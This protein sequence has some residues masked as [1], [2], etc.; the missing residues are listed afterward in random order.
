[1]QGPMESKSTT[2]VQAERLLLPAEDASVQ[3]KKKGHPGERKSYREL[4]ELSG[5]GWGTRR[6]SGRTWNAAGHRGEKQH[7]GSPLV[8]SCSGQNRYLL[9]VLFFFFSCMILGRISGQT[10]G[11]AISHRSGRRVD[12]EQ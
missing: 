7:G 2:L 3:K 8:F 11:A 1:M 4:G 12:K 5:T 10:V 6:V 9:F